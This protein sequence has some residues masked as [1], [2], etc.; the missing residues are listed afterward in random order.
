MGFTLLSLSA[1]KKC[2]PKGRHGWQIEWPV[3]HCHI[4]Q[5]V[6]L[7]DAKRTIPA[8]TQRDSISNHLNSLPTAQPPSPGYSNSTSH[9][10]WRNW[11]LQ[12]TNLKK[13]AKH[14]SNLYRSLSFE[15]QNYTT[16]YANWPLS[17]SSVI[18]C[19]YLQVAITE[20]ERERKK[21]KKIDL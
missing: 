12:M 13:R 7:I 5:S 20:T 3:A 9:R 10:R 6:T 14:K 17:L 15:I 21:R 4:H 16:I 19:N 11:I 2:W 1:S 18:E 8:G